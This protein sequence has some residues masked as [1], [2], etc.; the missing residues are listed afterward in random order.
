MKIKLSIILLISCT[1]ALSLLSFSLSKP[2]ST[3]YAANINGTDQ[4]DFLLGTNRSDIINGLP[5]DDII[6]GNGGNDTL[7]GDQGD[8]TIFGG[9]GG[10]L[11][12]RRWPWR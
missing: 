6:F 2:I 5:G 3:A 9:P 4:D 11:T 7:I 12:Y 8:D 10:Q 1:S